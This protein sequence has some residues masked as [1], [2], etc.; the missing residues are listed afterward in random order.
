MRALS[1][2]GLLV[3]LAYLGFVGLG[4]RSGVLGV[5]WPSMR[6]DFDVPLDA[7]GALL[8]PFAVGYMLGSFVSGRVLVRW[9]LG[10]VLAASA[11]GI[12]I[13]LL[14]FAVAPAWWLLL[15]L[16]LPG[17]LGTGLI[18]AGLNI[19]V[20]NR[21]GPREMNWLHASW[22]IGVTL[23]PLMMTAAVTSGLGWR[24]GYALS[25][26][27]LLA[28][29]GAYVA[30]SRLW[31]SRA[32]VTQLVPGGAA[33]Q[34]ATMWQTL[35][36][37]VAWL[38]MLLFVAYTGVELGVGLWAFPFLVEARGMG[39]VQAGTAVG[40]YWAGLTL[41]RLFFGTVVASIGVQRL[42]RVCLLSVLL[43]LG[44]LWIPGSSGMAFA[45]LAFLGAVQAPIFPLLVTVTPERFGAAHTAN[46]VG[47]QVA[48][49]VIGGSGLPALLGFLAQGFGLA[50]IVPTLLINALIQIVC[51][52]AYA[53][54]CERSDHPR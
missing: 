45:T 44:V 10:G 30:T 9:N 13:N 38:S 33:E 4:V 16:G 5:A 31:P 35:R 6:A 17:G 8:G 28:L 25:G 22:G 18:D 7:L 19:Y 46:A 26:L 50:V 20:A 39:T 51:Y 54:R 32:D 47:F 48:A 49:S 29:N 2:P 11:A 23:S 24:W 12:A 37:P 42:L 3:G 36:L 52:L 41:G 27:L 40:A 15:A 53:W 14:G 1:R 43:G 34:A 21:Q